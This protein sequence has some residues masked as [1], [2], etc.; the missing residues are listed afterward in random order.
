[1]G[2]NSLSTIVS[3]RSWNNCHFNFIH[4]WWILNHGINLD[5]TTL[6]FGSWPKQ[7]LAKV[8]AKWEGWESH[9]MLLRMWKS[10]R[11]WSLTLPSEFSLW[12]LKSWRILKSSECDCKSQNSL[13]FKVPYI[14]EKMLE[15]E[16]LKWAHMT[17]LDTSNTSYGQK[18]G[19]ESN[20]QFGFQPQ[21]VGNHLDFLVCR[22]HAT[23][24]WNAF[25]EGYN[26][27]SNLISIKGFHTK[28]WV[29]K[30]S[31]ITKIPTLGILKLPLGSPRTKWHLSASLVA[32][33][34]VYYKGEGDGFPQVRAVMSLVSPWLP[35]V[36]S[37]HQNVPTTT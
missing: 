37:V 28:S 16:C 7:G 14:I 35:A 24:L 17:H 21:K 30:V 4:Q 22:W 13:D 19:Q 8:R 10:V 20:W 6:T 31:K 5:V 26:F 32:R 15:L 11:E 27:A 25:D 36:Q 1:M 9:F 3:I 12:E 29:P 2:V 23:Y 18:K 33:H 34:I